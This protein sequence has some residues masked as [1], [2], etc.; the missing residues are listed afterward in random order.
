MRSELKLRPYQRAMVEQLLACDRTALWAEM[1]LGKTVSAL[2]ALAQVVTKESPALVLAPLRVAQVTWPAE[3][4]RWRHLEHLT[5]QQ[6]MGPPRKRLD[7]LRA[8]AHIYTMNYE[9]LPWL[10]R[11][12]RG[13]WPFTTVVADESTRLKGFR[14]RQGSARARALAAVAHTSVKRLW[15]L[16]GTPSPN[17]LQ[18]LW[19][20]LW[21]LDR[22]LRLGKTYSAFMNRW[23]SRRMTGGGFPIWTPRASASAEIHSAVSDICY[24]VRAKDHLDIREP[25]EAMV[26]VQLPAG[27]AKVYRDL[28]R[29]MFAN[30]QAGGEV[31]AVSAAALTSKCLQVASGAVYDADG[32]WHEVHSEKLTALDSIVTEACGAPLLVGYQ[33]RHEAERI[34]RQ[35]PQARMLAQG[36][37]VENLRAWNAGEVPMLLAHPASCGHGLNLQDGGNRLVLF[38]SGWN[39]EEHQQMLERIGPTRQAQAGHDRP[40]FVYSIVAEGTLDVSVR[41]RLL[42][43]RSVQD[44][45]LEAARGGHELPRSSL[46]TDRITDRRAGGGPGGALPRPAAGG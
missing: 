7:A 37:P 5:V 8:G 40:V 11:E 45:L 10:V 25:I 1:G 22:G 13:D 4:G 35:F 18:D 17:G 3:V 19:G 30:L 39:L 29:D 44:C 38:S 31:D 2:T 20:Q 12:L 9:G 27:A 14:M 24:S 23:F 36:D 33:F 34:R 16:T 15:Q 43:K 28:E 32:A 46:G 6:V 41:Q 26:P 42:T 21:F